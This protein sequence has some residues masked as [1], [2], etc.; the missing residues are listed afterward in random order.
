M[1][2]AAEKAKGA[3]NDPTKGGAVP[4]VRGH[5]PTVTVVVSRKESLSERPRVF[6][7]M[8]APPLLFIFFFYVLQHQ[9]KLPGVTA[10][11]FLP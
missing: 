11:T 8:Y 5:F 3:F 4:Q 7:V 9:L 1:M 6:H 2:Q 10:A